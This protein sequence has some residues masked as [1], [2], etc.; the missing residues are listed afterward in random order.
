MLT[1]FYWSIHT[2]PG[3]TVD[4]LITWTNWTTQDAMDAKYLENVLGINLNI[5]FFFT[6]PGNQL[7]RVSFAYCA[8]HINAK[9]RGIATSPNGKSDWEFML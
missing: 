4:S 2:K 9:L 8:I 3:T 7:L 6:E 1:Q 5:D